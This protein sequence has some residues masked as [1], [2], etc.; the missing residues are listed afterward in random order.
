MDF[1]QLKTLALDG[2]LYAVLELVRRAEEAKVA[3]EDCQRLFREA[4]PKFNWAASALDGGAIELLNEV[5][6]TVRHAIGLLE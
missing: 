1:D 6:Q 3:L 4:L 5:P 2:D